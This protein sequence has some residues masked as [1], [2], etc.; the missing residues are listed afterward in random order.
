VRE[1]QTQ[2]MVI[3]GHSNNHVA[4]SSLSPAEQEADLTTCAKVLHERISPQAHWPFCYPYGHSYS[5]NATTI[6]NLRAL[7]FICSFTTEPGTSRPGA[8]LFTLR[9]VDTNDILKKIQPKQSA[10]VS[11]I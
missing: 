2:G 10:A 6:Q 11:A 4:L 1:M 8:D 9:R 5:F 3:G 7:G